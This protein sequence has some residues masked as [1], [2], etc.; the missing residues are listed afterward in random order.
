MSRQT[1]RFFPLAVVLAGLCLPASGCGRSKP[2]SVASLGT[3]TAGTTS[4]SV[5]R[6][7]RQSALLYAGCMRAQGV[8]NFPDPLP[9]GRFDIP[10]GVKFEPE[11]QSASQACQS[12]L[13]NAGT[14][15]KHPDV[16]EDLDFARCMRSHGITDFPDPLPGGGFNLPGNTN[17]PQ[18]EAAARAC[19]TTGVHWNGPP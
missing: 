18:F 6:S 13:P 7:A 16:R 12:D 10:R 4:T 9:D 11:F 15:S 3:T 17:S 2:S 19:Q 14:S 5:P 1:A 8:P